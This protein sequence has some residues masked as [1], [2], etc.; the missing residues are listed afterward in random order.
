MQKE[1]WNPILYFSNSNIYPFEE[2]EKR[3]HELLKVAEIY[4][5]EVIRELYDHESWLKA[6]QGH[7]KEAEGGSRCT[8]CFA[9]NLAEANAKAIELGFD[10]FTTTLTVSRFKNSATIF[11]VGEE[12]ERF[13]AINFKKQGGFDR[14]TALSNEYNLYRQHYCGCEFSIRP[15]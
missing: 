6:I 11:A 12:F 2:A 5:L 9:Y 7:E 10:H 4:N 1:G 3:Y 15:T 8:R 14:S 13:E